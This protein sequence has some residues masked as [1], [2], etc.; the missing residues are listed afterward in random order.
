[1]KLST[2]IMV[3]VITL[4]CGMGYAGGLS[5]LESDGITLNDYLWAYRAFYGNPNLQS[6]PQINCADFSLQKNM[7]F[8]GHENDTVFQWNTVAAVNL[9]NGLVTISV[10]PNLIQNNHIKGIWYDKILDIIV[11][12][13][14][15][16]QAN[17]RTP[18]ISIIKLQDFLAGN[19]LWW[20]SFSF[21]DIDGLYNPDLQMLQ[22]SDADY[23]YDRHTFAFANEG[24]DHGSGIIEILPAGDSYS[25]RG[26][27]IGNLKP[28]SNYCAI[29]GNNIINVST[30]PN[31]CWGILR[32]SQLPCASDCPYFFS[33]A[34]NLAG[35]HIYNFPWGD[36]RHNN[37]RD[38]EYYKNS[39][40]CENSSENCF[41]FS[42]KDATPAPL[43]L[44][45]GAYVVSL[46]NVSPYPNPTPT[47]SECPQGPSSLIDQPIIR[48]FRYPVEADNEFHQVFYD[49]PK[50]DLWFSH[51]NVGQVF[52]VDA[53]D[54]EYT[55]KYKSETPTP[56]AGCIDIFKK[57]NV[58]VLPCGQGVYFYP[59]VAGATIIDNT[60]S[61][62][63]FDTV[64]PWSTANS[65][66]YK[67]GPD[68]LY[69]A[70]SRSNMAIWSFKSPRDAYYSVGA[71]WGQGINRTAYATYTV[72]RRGKP[73]RTIRVDQTK[74]CRDWFPL[75]VFHA[76]AG[77]NIAVT[78]SASVDDLNPL[79][80]MIADA[81][82]FRP[83]YP[84]G[85]YIVDNL[86]EGNNF[87]AS[88]W[89]TGAE[90]LGQ[91]GPDYRYHLC[92]TSGSFAEW[93][94]PQPGVPMDGYYSIW[95]MWPSRPN[96]TGAAR[97]EILIDGQS[98]HAIRGNHSANDGDGYDQ[99]KNDGQWVYLGTYALDH[100]QK[101][102]VRLYA[103]PQD[104][105]ADAHYVM[106]DAVKFAYEG[107]EYAEPPIID[108]T[109]TCRYWESEWEQDP[110]PTPRNWITGKSGTP[111][112]G[113]YRYHAPV[114]QDD[115]L[116][117]RA[118]W[119][120]IAPEVG[121]YDIY[122]WWVAAANRPLNAQY[123]IRCGDQD[124]IVI[125]KNQTQG[126]LEFSWLTSISAE[127]NQRIRVS[128]P[129]ATQGYVIADAIRFQ[130][131][132]Q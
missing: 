43:K 109:D 88:G 36:N 60:D 27:W 125:E 58:V 42:Y 105:R 80:Y 117:D 89:T 103:T 97:Y 49:A 7:L 72:A 121:T 19:M 119:A 17:N 14:N 41:A 46:A 13:S 71:K 132:S 69:A 118:S 33:R 122:A 9:S 79:K 16:T 11:V 95:A 120:V 113:Y 65:N 74:D 56:V 130:K 85:T 38:I 78:L 98:F 63:K 2:V 76:A 39:G 53:V 51:G 99:R 8:I 35:Q 23:D 102:S 59:P 37:Y 116:K 70:A 48:E 10:I 108:N 83:M 18:Y 64:G 55:V 107:C 129:A 106:A 127:R 32:L 61:K 6:C 114:T 67:L 77:E 34:L 92:D 128:L 112:G 22:V 44:P 54:Q 12:Y 25:V 4:I 73:A 24:D 110:S 31:S 40:A 30:V 26:A 131:R 28:G 5:T 45:S 3:S 68:Y 57:E 115:R 20:R 21:L 66:Q 104:V 126:C 111:C 91:F 82:Q 101:L 50:E 81:I 123:E 94:Y 93:R 15:I 90:R 75:G 1:M 29:A 124:P 96:R 47:S 86:D 62:P 100:D 84:R 52:M 87:S